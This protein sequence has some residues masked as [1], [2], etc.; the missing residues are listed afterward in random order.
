MV[1]GNFDSTAT[2]ITFEL[3]TVNISTIIWESPSRVYNILLWYYY[4]TYLPTERKKN[5]PNVG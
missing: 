4:Y 3:M 5:H 2:I 1:F